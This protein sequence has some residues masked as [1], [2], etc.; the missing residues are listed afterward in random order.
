[1]LA[2]ISGYTGSNPHLF[3]MALLSRAPGNYTLTIS[4]YVRVKSVVSHKCM[5]ISIYLS[6]GHAC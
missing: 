6:V 2:V 3:T 5:Q 4:N 1:M